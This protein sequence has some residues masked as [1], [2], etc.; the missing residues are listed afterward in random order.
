MF[1]TAA[2]KTPAR[3]SQATPVH[4]ARGAIY[5]VPALKTPFFGVC[6]FPE[7]FH[8][9]FP[10]LLPSSAGV[11]QGEAAGRSFQGW[12]CFCPA[13]GGAGVGDGLVSSVFPPGGG[14]NGTAPPLMVPLRM[15]SAELDRL[16]FFPGCRSR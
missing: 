5:G 9:L 10:A 16:T 15:L 7:E 4:R 8:R 3:R 14:P 1:K 2:N 6:L 11:G 12:V 13:F